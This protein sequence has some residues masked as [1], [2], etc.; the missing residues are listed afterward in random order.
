MPKKHAK[1]KKLTPVENE[2]DAVVHGD[3]SG[4]LIL[5]DVRSQDNHA[6]QEMQEHMPASMEEE[7]S[8]EDLLDDVRRSL[9]EEDETDRSNR[10]SR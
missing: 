8:T 1:S 6:Y 7:S 10:E 2:S 5:P 4:D 3:A 9:I